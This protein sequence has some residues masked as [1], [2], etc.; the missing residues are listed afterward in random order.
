MPHAAMI[1]AAATMGVAAVGAAVAFE[2]AVFKPWRE[3]NYPEGFAEGMRTEWKE[4]KDEFQRGFCDFRERVRNE[5]NHQETNVDPFSDIAIRPA[6]RRSSVLGANR[7]EGYHDDEEYEEMRQV[8]RDL[9]EFE[10]SERQSLFMNR[11]LQ[12]EFAT[13]QSMRRRKTHTRDQREH[14][15]NVVSSIESDLLRSDTEKAEYDLDSPHHNIG[16]FSPTLSPE[17]L[18]ST[19]MLPGITNTTLQQDATRS[20]TVSEDEEWLS[21][22]SS[23][24]RIEHDEDGIESG[25]CSDAW[26]QLENSPPGTPSSGSWSAIEHSSNGRG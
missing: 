26:I 15:E 9:D 3:E 11:R 2:I 22:A 24:I 18:K 16:T 19:T 13:D 14:D 1:A 23:P 17:T 25:N 12:N 7:S 4:F 20:S 21:R 8:Q 5:V 6:Q 10:M